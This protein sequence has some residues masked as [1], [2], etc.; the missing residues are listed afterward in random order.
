MTNT[1]TFSGTSTYNKCVRRPPP[2]ELP[3]AR[4]ATDDVCAACPRPEPLRSYTYQNDVA[5]VSGLLRN[6]SDGINHYI[7]VEE[8]GYP[9]I[10]GLVAVLTI[11]ITGYP[12]GEGCVA[13]ALMRAPRLARA[14]AADGRLPTL[15]SSRR[16]SSGALRTLWLPSAF[17]L[18]LGVL[19]LSLHGADLL[20]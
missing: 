19:T 17:A 18:A 8:D 1:T 5:Y 3:R 10:D 7:T 11:R 13:S 9:A 6:S 15:F 4:P 20:P 2:S 14:L 12:E 16:P